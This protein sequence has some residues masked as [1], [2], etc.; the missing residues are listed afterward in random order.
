MWS[1]WDTFFK[2]EIPIPAAI[3]LALMAISPEAD[4][5]RPLRLCCAAIILTESI[6]VIKR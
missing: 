3:C 2:V 1:A 5:V 4:C 6:T